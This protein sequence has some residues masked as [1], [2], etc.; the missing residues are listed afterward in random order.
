ME[1]FKEDL[2]Q[3]PR[4]FLRAK[5]NRKFPVIYNFSFF[6]TSWQDD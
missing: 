2:K 5:Y 3:R 4:P 6:E 1:V